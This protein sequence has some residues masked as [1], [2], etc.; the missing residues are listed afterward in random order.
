MALTGGGDLASRTVVKA[1]I[2]R[3]C[4]TPVIRIY[5]KAKHKYVGF[6]FAGLGFGDLASGSRFRDFTLRLN[7]VRD[8]P[9]WM[10]APLTWS[11]VALTA[12]A[13]LPLLVPQVFTP[14]AH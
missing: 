14:G 11:T 4:I 10:S 1:A 9:R 13:S 8:R 6:R 5:L 12:V 3:L 7:I 2:V